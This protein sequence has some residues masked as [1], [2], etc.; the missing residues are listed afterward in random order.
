MT[1]K[2]N[3][4]EVDFQEGQTILEAARAAGI[5]IPT[6]C[7]LK[8]APPNGSCRICSVA[9]AGSDRLLPACETPAQEGMEV[10]TENQKVV[11]ARRTI[12]EMLVASGQHNCFVMEMDPDKWTEFQLEAMSTPGHDRICPA[13]GACEL[14]DLVV[15][16]G[17]RTDGLVPAQGPFPLDNDQPLILRDFSRC[18]QCGRCVAACNE[19]QV[20]LAIPHPYG[21]REDHPAPEG[22]YPLAD[23]DKCTH[24]GECVQA[25][26]VGALIERKASGLGRHWEAQKV[27]TT[28]PYCGVG[29]QMWLHVQEGKVV[30]VTG[31][32]GVVPNQGRLCVKGRF[33]YDFI[34]SED[35]LTTPLIRKDGRLEQA[36]WD[37][38]LDLVADKFKEIKDKRG[39]DAL[40]GL[41]S[42]RVTNEENYLMQKLVRAGFGTNNIDH[43]ARL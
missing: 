43:C 2:I 3:G 9:V 10:W 13:Y 42:A 22:W 8:D 21:R 30:K 14:Q 36:T 27:R 25:C 37:E 39:P 23:Y 5:Q 35:R 33:G 24:C 31:V 32:E 7:H 12:L 19:V 38:A 28:C 15:A 11:A 29:C 34:H 41:T 20:N 1:M 40:A 16:Y 4:R 18:I 26:P 6:L 17:V